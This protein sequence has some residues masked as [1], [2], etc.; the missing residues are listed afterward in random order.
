MTK[1]PSLEVISDNSQKTPDSREK[2][3]KPR[4]HLSSEQFRVDQ[5]GK[6]FSVVDLSMDGV[7]FRIL[8][9]ADQVMVPIASEIAGI[10]NLR[11]V[12][13][14]VR[15]QVKNIRS[16]VVGCQFI[17]LDASARTALEKFLDP[18][19]LGREL[20]PIPTAQG[21]SLWYHGPGG[22]DLLFSRALDGRYHRFTLFVLGSFIQWD[23]ESGATTGRA[24]SS[25]DRRDQRS[26][27]WGAVQFETIVLD[28]DTQPDRDKLSIAK[29]LI[30]S[31]NLP[32]DLKK[33]CA[34][35]L[36][37]PQ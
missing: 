31:S 29:D 5:T 24:V 36:T 13:L 21:A 14:P 34:R 28:A 20:K 1:S 35:Q 18:A 37:L 23:E 17:D 9:H 8:D 2:R 19:E 4:I 11:G 15:V 12:K 16:Q 27:E 33:W 6:L 26:E 25:E 3:K 10:L 32:Q 7:A 30:L 22:T